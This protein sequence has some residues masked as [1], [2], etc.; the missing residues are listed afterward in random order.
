MI[1]FR[2]FLIWIFVNLTMLN[3]DHDRWR[4]E[5]ILLIRR[6][7]LPDSLFSLWNPTVSDYRI[8][9]LQTP[10]LEYFLRDI[11]LHGFCENCTIQIPLDCT[12]FLVICVMHFCIKSWKWTPNSFVT[13]ILWE[14]CLCICIKREHRKLFINASECTYWSI[15]FLLIHQET[16]FSF[17]FPDGSKIPVPWISW[18]KK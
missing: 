12:F 2:S 17:K 5:S 8:R 10:V 15:I 16:T 1:Q 18:E 14:M 6:Q 9:N 13:H 11:S 7:K 4:I 3:G